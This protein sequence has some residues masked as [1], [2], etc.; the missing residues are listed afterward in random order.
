MYYPLSQITTNLYTNGGE[1]QIKSTGEKYI[2][3]YWKASDGKIFTGRT[4]QDTP[5]QELIN[6]LNLTSTPLSNNPSSISEIITDYYDTEEYAFNP[7]DNIAYINLK[8]INPDTK[9]LIPFYSPTL[10]TS[11][12]YQLGEMR[13]YFC[14][15]SNEVIYLEINKETYDKLV[16][17]DSTIAYQYYI[18]FNIPWQ[19]TGTKEQTYKVNKNIVELTMKQQKLP[20]F[21]LYLKKDY[22]KYTA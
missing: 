16:V 20:M 8:K 19:I 15:K 4:P 17:K 9:K 2:G 18:P 11:Q 5:I 7:D 22:T 3:Y 21:D 14:K 1:Y 6:I 13:R 12:D 10:P